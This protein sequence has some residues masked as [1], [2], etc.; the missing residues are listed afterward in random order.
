MLKDLVQDWVHDT[1][2]FW[3]SLPAG[4]RASWRSAL[5]AWLL[6]TLAAV[7]LLWPSFESMV[8]IWARSDT[9]AHGYLV[10][11]AVLWLIWRRR[12]DCLVLQPRPW[13]P[14]LGGLLLL[15]PAW[16][17]VRL[18]HVNAAEHFAIV[19]LLVLLVP[20]IFGRAVGVRLL[21]PLSFSFFAVPFGEFMLPVL[22]N[23]T[24]DF[25][26]AALRATGI[27]VYREGLE[28]IIPSGHW[29]V[30]EA[31]SGIR[32][33]IAS[34]MVGTLFA[35]INY[36]SPWRRGVFVLVSLVVPLIANWLRAYMIV[37]IGHLSG[38]ELATGV[39]HIV[40]GWVFF[41]LVMLLLY[42]VGIRYVDAPVVEP[43]PAVPAQVDATRSPWLQT[44]LAFVL[45][46]APAGW[47]HHVERLADAAAPVALAP[48]SLE[49]QGWARIEG[50]GKAGWK[51]AYG[52][53][54]AEQHACYAKEG[55]S[56]CLWV[57]FY[58]GQDEERK[59]MNSENR[60][61]SSKDDWVEVPAGTQ[62]A[63]AV[64][65]TAGV[66]RPALLRQRLHLSG[67]REEL[68]VQQT[69]WVD[70][71]FT[72]SSVRARLLTAWCRLAG[73]VDNAAAVFIYAPEVEE[74]TSA[75]PDLLPALTPAIQG[76]LRSQSQ[77]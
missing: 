6:C 55:R 36:R 27:P 73:R 28:F 18:A 41:G 17:V 71:Q 25:T 45:L 31:C 13:W 38:N 35:Y 24:A 62:Q 15:L 34:F 47:A 50:L 37:M 56:F 61:A 63:A 33:L 9:F 42:M 20:L 21:F 44:A 23:S 51:P 22:M 14:A 30:V 57:M 8:G 65:G 69:H 3:R 68:K 53:A 59:V 12:Y 48:L 75:L 76:Y 70:G 52:G 16:L 60:L 74:G 19:A 43:R 39:D 26:V 46:A 5:L 29:S 2:S 67:S 66:W 49:A 77:H 7:G 4:L 54:S 40:Y 32:Y 1:R 72:N 58:R 10:F 64:G 11:P